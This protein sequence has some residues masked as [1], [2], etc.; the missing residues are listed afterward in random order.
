MAVKYRS[1][2]IGVDNVPYRLDISSDAHLGLSIPIEGSAVLGLNS[3]E[4]ISYPL[5]SKFL[6]ISLLAT[7]ENDLNDL[8]ASNEREWKVELF[9]DL[10]KIF[11]GYLSSEGATQSFVTKERIVDFDVLDPIAY[12][13]DLSYV[14]LNG[15]RFEDNAQVGQII[16]RCLRRGFESQSDAFNIHTYC[17]LDY[18]IQDYNNGNDINF[19]GGRF[20]KDVTIPQ[21]NFY[22]NESLEPVSCQTV[23]IELLSDLGLT[24]TQVNGATWVIGHYLYDN[25]TMD[26]KYINSLDKDGNDI[27]NIDGVF[28]PQIEIKTDGLN[29][30]KNDIIHANENQ[31]Y[32]YKRGLQK[33]VLDYR[34]KYKREITIN[35]QLNTDDPGIS[36][37]NWGYNDDYAT[38]NSSSFTITRSIS[39][40]QNGTI[41]IIS[42]NSNIATAGAD[43][44]LL[45]VRGSFQCLN[46]PV[47]PRLDFNIRA[48]NI[49]TGQVSYLQFFGTANPS[50]RITQSPQD[51]VDISGINNETVEFEYQIPTLI[52]DSIVELVVPNIPVS[53]NANAEITLFEI[54][55]YAGTSERVGTSYINTAI[56]DKSLT[57]DKK[58]INYDIG[59]GSVR[60]N[61][62]YKFSLGNPITR[63]RNRFASILYVDSIGE[64][65]GVD[66]L[67][68]Q[69]RRIIFNGDFWNYF[70]PSAI[71][72]IP[73]LTSNKLIVIDYSF[74]TKLNIG[75][76]VLEERHNANINT[77]TISTPIYAQTVQP[78]IE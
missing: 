46:Y 13:Q 40:A 1:Q 65:K 52:S 17:N 78:T 37:P 68:R 9:Q 11:F 16:A 69:R 15:T 49:D 71:I 2:Y 73:S 45:T 70:D 43:A 67:K 56:D 39:A 21:D 48:T 62:F 10:K 64:I 31:S 27:D 34:Q 55:I 30:L 33:L 57:S 35:S 36:M 51:F 76:L 22:D 5:R 74:D 75:S 23:L 63:I 28:Y 14:D 50:W 26:A 58:D 61:Q 7:M 38:P 25:T 66:E 20:I 19:T 32:S 72:A 41:A 8:F 4:D 59:R 12:L 6:R 44:D 29:V 60:S 3:V 18:Q 24:V 42:N 53:A 47:D 77:T 54:G